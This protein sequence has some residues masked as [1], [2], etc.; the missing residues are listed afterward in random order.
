MKKRTIKFLA[1]LFALVMVFSACAKP[2]DDEPTDPGESKDPVEEPLPTE[3]GDN[4]AKSDETLVVAMSGEPTKLTCLNTSPGN[5]DVIVGDLLWAPLFEMNW[6]T[7]EFGPGLATHYEEIDE[8]HYR[9]FLDERACFEDGTPVT[10]EDCVWTLKQYASTGAVQFAAYFDVDG[11]VVEDEHTFILAY[12][13]YVPGWNYEL[14]R[15]GI[16]SQAAVEAAG[17]LEAIDQNPGMTCG[18]YKLA[19]WAPGEYILCERN[20]NYWGDYV[21]YYKYIKFIF[22]G[23]AASRLMAVQSG[24]ADVALSLGISQVMPL[25]NDPNVDVA[26]TEVPGLHN[27]IYFNSAEGVF[28]D[29]VVREAVSLMIDAEAMNQLVN[30]GKG[31][32]AQGYLPKQNENYFEYYEGGVKPFDP[33]KGIQMLK[34]A[35]YGDG[36]DLD[37]PCLPTQEAMA[38]ILQ[39]NLRAANINVNIRVLD[40]SVHVQGLRNGVYDLSFSSAAYPVM[41]ADIFETLNPDFVGKCN[42]GARISDLKA[43]EMI[44]KARSSD[45]ATAKEGITEFMTWVYENYYLAGLNTNIDCHVMAKGLVGGPLPMVRPA[46]FSVAY[47]HPAA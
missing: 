39:E 16:H 13:E 32:L 11:L 46:Q 44:A 45:P 37:L 30:M 43:I 3:T 23:D 33:E 42:G 17:G 20:E 9:I 15:E 36:F 4:A 24:D 38:V 40:A 25:E 18:K 29:P 8:T 41:R 31:E 7:L 35:G 12:K 2:A 27:L 1:L 21:G 28:T 6:E 19:E 34:D 47:V 26:Y 10:A 22:V 14:T 5:N